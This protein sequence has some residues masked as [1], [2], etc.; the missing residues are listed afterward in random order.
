VINRTPDL[1]NRNYV[2]GDES[3]RQAKN[4]INGMD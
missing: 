4:V 2:P 3:F 1:A